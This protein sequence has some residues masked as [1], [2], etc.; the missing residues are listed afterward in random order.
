VSLERRV[1]TT[2][3]V[4]IISIAGCSEVAE[5]KE[6]L[7]YTPTV[8][9]VSTA[10]EEAKSKSSEVLALLRLD[11]KVTEPG[12]RISIC[13]DLD[14]DK[15]FVTRHPWSLFGAP[16]EDMQQAMERLKEQLPQKGW[17][18]TS[19]GTN[20]SRAKSLELKAESLK[21]KFS[22]QVTLQDR[23]GRS[24]KPSMIEV[25]LDSSCYEV[26]EGQRVTEY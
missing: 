15:Y 7:G 3:A 6:A 20:S 17:E 9:E 14:P 21:D 13:G 12:P 22:L 18:I 11:G 4:S 26:P 19:Y 1:L 2:A 10:R 25:T 5:P 8:R 16:I 24:E 23:R